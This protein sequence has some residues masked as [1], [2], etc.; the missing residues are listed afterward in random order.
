MNKAKS[1][2]KTS[3][4]IGV[5]NG[6]FFALVMAVFDYI[7]NKPFLVKQFLFYLF[8]FGLSMALCFRFKYTK[9]K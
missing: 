7:D 5:F 6:L 3:L 4:K 1:P 9:T 8:F 2:F